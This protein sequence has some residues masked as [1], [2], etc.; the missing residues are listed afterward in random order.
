MSCRC[1]RF[2]LCGLAYSQPPSAAFLFHPLEDKFPIEA[3]SPPV[4]LVNVC[5]PHPSPPLHNR[6]LM[7]RPSSDSPS[8]PGLPPS[9]LLLSA[10]PGSASGGLLPALGC[11]R[12]AG[13]SCHH[14]NGCGC[15]YFCCYACWCWCWCW[16]FS[17]IS[18]H[19]STACQCATLLFVLYTSFSLPLPHRPLCLTPVSAVSPRR[20]GIPCC[21]GGSLRHLLLGEAGRRG[22]HRRSVEAPLCTVASA[23]GY[24]GRTLPEAYPKV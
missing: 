4:S 14:H 17:P 15:C 21:G 5:L 20:E 22:A 10:A 23:I 8:S 13:C 16:H 2:A 11:R 12:S 3:T 1:V 9:A 18:S 7:F 6:T 24:K 19:R